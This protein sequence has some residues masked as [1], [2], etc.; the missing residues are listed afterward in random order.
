MTTN[1]YALIVDDHPLLGSGTAQFIKAQGLLDDALNVCDSEAALDIVQQKGPPCIAIVDFWLQSGVSVELVTYLRILCP[2]TAILVISGDTRAEVQ[3]KA[4]TWGARGFVDKQAAPSVFMQAIVAILGGMTWFQEDPADFADSPGASPH[5]A[6]TH[7]LPM[8]P[9]ELGLSL[10]QGQILALVLQGL[11][12]KRIAQ[13]LS[14]TESTIKEHMTY[15][16]H[17]LAVG[18]R[19]EAI[20]KLR[21]C[22][23]V[24]E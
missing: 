16:L 20:T 14:V 22:R 4:R 7:D 2:S 24:V 5:R 6:A 1:G 3:A 11:P 19:V 12:N 21:G 18:N 10:R 23:L 15:I 13:A 17:K 8:T 9:A